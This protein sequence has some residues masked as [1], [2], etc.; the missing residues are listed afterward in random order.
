LIPPSLAFVIYSVMMPGVGLLEL[1]AAGL[2]PGLLAGLAL[3]L[4]AWW[5]SLR[6]GLGAREATLE[7]PSLGKSFREASWGLATPVL[8]LGGMRVGWFTPTEAAVVAAVYVLLVG[9]FV[10]RSIGV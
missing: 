3:V 7:R 10:H 9:M 1:F 5:L 8:I 2:V 6:H 4:P